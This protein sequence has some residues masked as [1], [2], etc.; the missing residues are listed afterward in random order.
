MSWR[1]GE[2]HADKKKTNAT[3]EGQK[4]KS[5]KTAK[6]RRAQREAVANSMEIEYG[7]LK[8]FWG[9]VAELTVTATYIVPRNHPIFGYYPN[10]DT[11]NTFHLFFFWGLAKVA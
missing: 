11:R 2:E 4:T 5:L 8:P 9:F 1:R 10:N 7:H 3:E 6:T